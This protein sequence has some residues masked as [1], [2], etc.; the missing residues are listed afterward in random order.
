MAPYLRMAEFPD[1]VLV[2]GEGER[3]TVAFRRYNCY[4]SGVR[5]D[6]AGMGPRYEAAGAVRQTQTGQSNCRLIAAKDIIDITVG[7][8]RMKPEEIVSYDQ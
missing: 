5:R 4:Q 7:L 2:A 1:A 6:L 8:L 3:H